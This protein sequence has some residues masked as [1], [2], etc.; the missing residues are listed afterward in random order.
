[1]LVRAAEGHKSSHFGK[2]P[3]IVSDLGGIEQA[4]KVAFGDALGLRPDFDSAGL[5]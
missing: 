5:K 3:P 4:A 2:T 1:M